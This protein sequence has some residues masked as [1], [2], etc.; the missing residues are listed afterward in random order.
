MALSCQ[1][2]R[3]T[4]PLVLTQARRAYIGVTDDELRRNIAW[5]N[6]ILSVSWLGGRNVAAW[7][8]MKIKTRRRVLRILANQLIPFYIGS[9][10]FE[11][12]VAMRRAIFKIK[13]VG[14]P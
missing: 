5:R 3:K 10:L 8:C 14:V 11:K 2:F 4:V 9:P 12:I 7:R 1:L 13:G 6:K